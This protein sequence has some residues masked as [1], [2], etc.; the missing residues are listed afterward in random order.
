MKLSSRVSPLV[1]L[2]LVLIATGSTPAAAS[3][4]VFSSSV[5]RFEVDGNVFGPFDGTVDYVDDFNGTLAPDWSPLLGTTVESGG[6]ATFE[7][8]GTDLTIGTVQFDVSNI[9]NEDDITNGMGNATLNSY[10]VPVLPNPGTEFH[11]QLYGI[12]STIEAAGLA[13]SSGPARR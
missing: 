12:G 9:E 3:H 2:A 8:P 7:N 13:V 10:W 1:F 6:V 11:L 5:D 4:H